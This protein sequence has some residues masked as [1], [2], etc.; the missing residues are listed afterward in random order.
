MIFANHAHIYPEHVNPNGTVEALKRYMDE[1]GIDKVVAF[2]TFANTLRKRD[3]PVYNT[4]KALYDEIKDDPDIVGF[5]TVDTERDDIE[6]QIDEIISYGFKG[7]KVHPQVQKLKVDGERAFRI[8]KKCEGSGLFVS[9]H[10]GVHWDRL[11]NNRV[12]LFDEVAWNFPNMKFSMEHVGGYSYFNE[13]LAVILNNKR[14]GLQPRIYA[15]WTTIDGQYRPWS[16]SDEQLY[17][18]L[19]QTSDDNSIFGLDFPFNSAEYTKAAIARIRG[20]D[21][22]EESKEKILGL[23]LAKALGVEL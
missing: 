12:E 9:F 22:P 13:A 1:T 6:D 5:G 10:T 11:K 18:L 19:G 14:S 3:L 16:L 23:N 7:I 20:L 2:S 15:G 8:Y 21:I 17:V 4:N